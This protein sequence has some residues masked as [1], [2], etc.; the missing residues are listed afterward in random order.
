[1]GTINEITVVREQEAIGQ[2]IHQLPPVR[3]V[4]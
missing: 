1:M 4:V 3:P 2:D